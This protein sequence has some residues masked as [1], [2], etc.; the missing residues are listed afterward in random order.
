LVKVKYSKKRRIGNLAEDIAALFLVKMGYKILERNYLKKWGE[1][2]IIAS[3]DSS[4]H[5]IEIKSCVTRERENNYVSHTVSQD[6]FT[7]R[8][9]RII[10]S[11][12]TDTLDEN[13]YRPEENVTSLKKMRIKRAIQTFLSEREI[14]DQQ[15]WQVDIITIKVDYYKKTAI[16]DLVENVVLE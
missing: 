11:R 13:W 6:C 8:E 2:D 16:I 10:F 1:L 4:L 15:D 3:K 9:F 14:D 7:A 5:F 12:E